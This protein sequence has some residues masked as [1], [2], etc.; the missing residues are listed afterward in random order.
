MAQL[1]ASMRRKRAA[2]TSI[3]DKPPTRKEKLA[4]VGGW[5]LLLVALMVLAV[6]VYGLY[7]V[8]TDAHVAELNVVGTRS[9]AENSQVMKHVTPAVTANYF[10]SDLEQI[11]DQALELSW[12]DRV[13]VSRAWPNSIRVRVMPRHAIAR[14]GTGRLLS[15]S[16]DIFAEVIPQ[17]N[18]KLPLL[19][20]PASQSKMMMRRYNEINQ[21][22]LPVNVRLKELYLTERMTWFMQF[23]S[24]LR[25]IVDQDQTMSKLQ[26]L[27]HLA[28]SDLKPVWSK[29]SSID[30]RYRN[31]LAIQWKNSAPPNIVNG[32]FVVTIDDTSIA[33]VRT[34]KP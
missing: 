21:L 27:S 4:N 16:G 25:I 12:V 6:G 15:D 29:I 3:H 1:P 8:M 33:D 5:L 31:G 2:I 11:R 24:G 13:V 28:Q 34:V 26:R 17:N 30:L 10:T 9:D 14:W 19:H 32:H 7:T 18:Q 20:G 23:D 22:F